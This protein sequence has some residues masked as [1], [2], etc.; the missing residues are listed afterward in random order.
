[1]SLTAETRTTGNPLRSSDAA[2]ACKGIGNSELVIR[3]G[4]LMRLKGGA[5]ALRGPERMLGGA[6]N[7]TLREAPVNG[8]YDARPVRGYRSALPVAAV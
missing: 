1:M 6:R 5:S 2:R 8:D 3:Q 7:V 4:L